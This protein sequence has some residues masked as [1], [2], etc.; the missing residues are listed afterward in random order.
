MS[1]PSFGVAY[2]ANAAEN[3]ERYFVPAIGAPLAEDLIDAA[4]LRDG[5]HVLDIACGT[6]VVTRLAAERVGK[7][8]SVAGLDVNPGMLAVAR[9]N[10]PSSTKIEWHEA[11][12]EKL[13]LDD[14]SIDVVLCQMGLQFVPDKPAALREMRRVV[15][16]KGRVLLN[17][18]GPTP[19]PFVTLANALA[20]HLNPQAGGFVNQVFS[21]HKTDEIT[22]LI[23]N[24]GFRDVTVTADTKTLR[25]PPPDEF[26]WQYIHSTPLGALAA[27]MEDSHRDALERDVVA[28]WQPHVKN[29]ALVLE[30]RVS[31]AIAR[32]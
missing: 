11:S 30:A 13:P 29:G 5:E 9:A 8:G 15:K 10:T 19:P 21:L 6:G 12:A 26:L 20:R 3:Y 22:R 16:Q 23:E 32:P 31:I 7:S 27:N 4:S 18:P 2:A 17:L 28:E 25:L 1:Q 24:A 14:G